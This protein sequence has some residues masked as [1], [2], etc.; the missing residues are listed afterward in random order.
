[1]SLTELMIVTTDWLG[2]VSSAKTVKVF[3]S[4]SERVLRGGSKPG[5]I[6]PLANGLTV[7]SGSRRRYCRR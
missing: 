1:M 2:F 4:L 3:T 5:Q 6:L 7:F